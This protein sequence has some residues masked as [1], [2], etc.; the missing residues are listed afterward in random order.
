MKTKNE[1]AGFSVAAF[2]RSADRSYLTLN[3]G[4]CNLYA[5]GSRLSM[6]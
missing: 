5:T 3:M 2:E 6:R 1:P 4:G